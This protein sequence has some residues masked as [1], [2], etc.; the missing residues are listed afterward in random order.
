MAAAVPSEPLGDRG[1]TLLELILVMVL[2]AIATSMA[3]PRIGAFLSTDQLKDAAR[4]LTGLITRASQLAQ[5]HQASY[6]LTYFEQEKRFVVEPERALVGDREKKTR[7]ERGGELRLSGQVVVRDIWS[8]YSG[9]RSV[10][11]RSIRFTA[12][13]YV[14]PTVIHLREGGDRDMSLVLSPFLGTIQIFDRYV[15]PD[16]PFIFQ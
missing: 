8:F 11:D 2:I 5:Q 16:D 15:S 10:G 13:G 7:S 14:E 9:N 6:R 3:L 12:D 4:G 1:F